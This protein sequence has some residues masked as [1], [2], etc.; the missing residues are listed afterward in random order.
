MKNMPFCKDTALRAIPVFLLAVV[1]I[2]QFILIES[3]ASQA[4]AAERYQLVTK[5]GSKGT[6][7]GQFNDPW[8]I[9]VDSSGNVYV[10]D[11]SNNCVQKFDSNGTFI[12]K[13]GSSGSGDGQFNELRGVCVDS[14]GNV[15][16][17]DHV[18]LRIQKFSSDGTFITK[19][20]KYGTGDGQFYYP[21]EIAV[22]SSGN[23]YVTEDSNTRVQKFSSSGVFITKWGSRGTGDGQFDSGP[24]GIAVDSSG[25]VYVGDDSMPIAYI[26]KF[27]S[28]GTFI[29][30][31]NLNG[32]VSYPEGIAVDSSGNI[33]VADYSGSSVSKF[34][35]SGTFI[36][37]I[38][39]YDDDLIS[40]RGV[41]VDSSG[42]VY[43][44]NS[45]KNQIQKY[46]PHTS[47]ATLAFDADSYSLE[48]YALVTL[49]D[50]DKNTDSSKV[51]SLINSIYI[52]TSIANITRVMMRET[53]VN[54]G[55]FQGSILVGSDDTTEYFQIK[56]NT[57]DTFNDYL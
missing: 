43:V 37:K 28:D 36:I 20:G 25:N 19:W 57:G 7:D 8:G 56:A 12:S 14:S 32:F 41:C 11:T 49:V 18:G 50:A 10:T 29:T 40:P 53:G 26:H 24:T 38:G 2:I 6:G 35:S 17:A 3:N 44:V 42:N 54:T 55:T 15:Y 16:V 46:S 21:C 1:S 5:W 47:D 4:N 23:V 33:Y 52:Q 45:G 30:K 9:A 34:S 48:S 27:N 22:D 39:S 31:W 13:W 51:Q